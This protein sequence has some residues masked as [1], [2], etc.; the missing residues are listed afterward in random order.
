MQSLWYIVEKDGVRIHHGKNIPQILLG[1]Q[2]ELQEIRTEYGRILRTA[3]VQ[4]LVRKHFD[5]LR[6]LYRNE[7]GV[8]NFVNG[9]EADLM[10]HVGELQPTQSM[11]GERRRILEQM[12]M[13]SIKILQDNSERLTEVPYEEIDGASITEFRGTEKMFGFGKKEHE[14]L[15]AGKLVKASGAPGDKK[16]IVLIK[17]GDILAQ[18]PILSSFVLKALKDG[19]VKPLSISGELEPEKANANVRLVTTLQKPVSEYYLSHSANAHLEDMFQRRLFLPSHMENTP[20]N[21][22]QLVQ[23][24][25]NEIEDKHL[26]H[27][28]PEALAKVM[29]YEMSVY[30]KN[31]L[32]LDLDDIV[33]VYTRANHRA[34]RDGSDSV[35][36]EH[37]E[38]AILDRYKERDR[39]ERNYRLGSKE[40]GIFSMEPEVGSVGGISV[41]V[42]GQYAG[43]PFRINVQAVPNAATGLKFKDLE[44]ISGLGKNTAHKGLMQVEALLKKLYHTYETP[45]NMDLHLS[46]FQSFN[47]HD[48]PSASTAYYVAATSALANIPIYPHVYFTGAIGPSNGEAVP[49]GGLNYKVMSV[50]NQGLDQGWDDTVVAFPDLNRKDLQLVFK[51]YRDVVES[52]KVRLYSYK[53]REEALEIATMVESSAIDAGIRERMYNFEI[54]RGVV[55]K[56]FSEKVKKKFQKEE[57][58][59]GWFA[60]LLNR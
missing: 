38:E 13:Y 5:R 58:K 16:G 34:K 6:F 15:I 18:S 37:V 52:G 22:E 17:D 30:S 35:N 27:A 28:T 45:L 33:D 49:I 59:K 31:I 57:L 1:L 4:G 54:Q 9:A 25:R 60:R 3:D 24:L 40:H 2:N 48:G 51:E 20:E 32:S 11:F 46:V 8:L 56:K 53:N 26:L 42:I 41:N 36:P 19:K 43:K 10:S 39:K 50:I 47:P 21:R 55:G 12:N 23:Y 14:K 7:G 29:E 44:N